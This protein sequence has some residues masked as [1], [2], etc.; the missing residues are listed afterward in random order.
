MYNY[1][2]QASLGNEMHTIDEFNLGVL[3]TQNL[4]DKE[5]SDSFTAWKNMGSPQT[6]TVDQ[7]KILEA[8]GQLKDADSP[9]Y[10]AP[11]NGKIKIK[12]ALKDKIL[13]Y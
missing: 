1:V 13:P 9:K 4:I 10:I 6:P 2:I 5:I 7:Y 3:V 8:A 11:L 12:F